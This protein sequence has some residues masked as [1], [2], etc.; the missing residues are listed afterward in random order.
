[1]NERFPWNLAA[2][3]RSFLRLPSSL[4][5][6]LI[7]KMSGAFA[8]TIVGMAT[9]SAFGFLVGISRPNRCDN[10]GAF[11]VTFGN[12]ICFAMGGAILGALLGAFC[13]A[14]ITSSLKLL[15]CG[16]YVF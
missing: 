11:A 12:G 16:A 5:L 2:A 4:F 1:M 10:A 9:G 6:V 15:L 7:I 14:L 13:G 3:Q 8:L